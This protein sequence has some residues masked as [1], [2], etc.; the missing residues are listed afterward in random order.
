MFT[1]D[2]QTIDS[3]GAFYVGELERLDQTL[4]MPLVDVTWNRDIDLRE[5]VSM[6][7]ETSS[8][9]NS[10]FAAAGGLN[11]SGK[12]WIGKTSN[13]IPG[14]GVDIGKTSHPLYPWGQEVAYTILELLSAQQ[15]G[16]PIDEQKYMG[17]KLKWNMDVDEQVYIGD[18]GLG[19]YGLVNNTTQVTTG[20]VDLNAGATSRA[21][22]AKTPAEIL[23]DVNALLTASWAAAGY[24]VCPGKLLLPPTQFGYIISQTVSTAGNISILEFLKK[25]SIC[26][27]KNGKELDIQPVKWL[28]GRGVAAG[29]PSAATDRMVC[30]TQDKMRIRMP[31][32]PIQRTPMEY[33]SL[34]QCVTYYGRIGVIEAVYPETVR[35]AD[36][37]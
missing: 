35:Y 9:T 7:D 33:R 8:F 6:A 12:N 36:G 1:Y 15:V 2:K 23:A 31:L 29:S 21:W 20:F 11:A 19:V 28:V 16:R 5:D 10:T 30:Y 37:I 26:M 18:S 25:N 24:A 22:T 14:M 32:V 34:Y 13:A 27:A 17:M 4:H 3:T